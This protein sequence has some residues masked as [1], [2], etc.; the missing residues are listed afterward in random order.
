MN[1]RLE[2]NNLQEDIKFLL[3]KVEEMVNSLIQSDKVNKLA[4]IIVIARKIYRLNNN[5]KIKLNEENLKTIEN[6]NHHLIYFFMNDSYNFKNL[7]DMCKKIKSGKGFHAGSSK[8][9]Q[10][11][12]KEET[13]MA[14]DNFLDIIKQKMPVEYDVNNQNPTFITEKVKGFFS[15][16]IE[17][18]IYIKDMILKIMQNSNR[19]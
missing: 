16:I 12:I 18:S 6:I 1:N 19:S 2:Y 3:S 8:L 17:K 5:E 13:I 11:L 7:L 4:D 15:T 10:L 14:I 9:N